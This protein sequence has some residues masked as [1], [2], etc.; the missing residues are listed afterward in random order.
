MVVYLPNLMFDL[1]SRW[2]NPNT[3][4]ELLREAWQGRRGAGA[5]G[6]GGC[7]NDLS[8]KTVAFVGILYSKGPGL[9]NVLMWNWL[10][11]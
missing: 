7:A 2:S 11:F 5:P 1:A 3:Y 4:P 6:Q 9:R 10:C 8:R